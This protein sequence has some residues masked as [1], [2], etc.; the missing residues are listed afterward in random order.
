MIA[1]LCQM[2][3]LMEKINS[4]QYLPEL[5]SPHTTHIRPRCWNLRF[6]FTIDIEFGFPLFI[7]ELASALLLVVIFC[8]AD[9]GHGNSRFAVGE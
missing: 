1:H 8:D 9:G 7:A 3:F 5:V 2:I 6:P 4:N